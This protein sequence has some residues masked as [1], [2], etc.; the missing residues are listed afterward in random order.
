[1]TTP[2]K[3]KIKVTWI[4]LFLVFVVTT[5]MF[6]STSVATCVEYAEG[7]AGTD[8]CTSKNYLLANPLLA[9]TLLAGLGWSGYQIVKR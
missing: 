6:A 2:A 9:V 8:G 7:V 3:P 1:M 5:T 4:L